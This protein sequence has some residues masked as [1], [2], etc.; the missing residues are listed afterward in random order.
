M[1]SIRPLPNLRCSE[2]DLAFNH[3]TDAGACKLFDALLAGAQDELST[4]RL[5][6]NPLT[7]E[8]IDASLAALKRA[9]PDM[10]T[11]LAPQLRGVS[12]PC[13]RVGIV[14]K[15]SPAARAGLQKGD[16]VLQWGMLQKNRPLAKRF[17][18]QPSVQDGIGEA[19]LAGCQYID[20]SSSISPLVRAFLGMPHDVIVRRPA[21]EAPPLA[22]PAAAA[23]LPSDGTVCLKLRLVPERWS[24]QGL[25]GCILK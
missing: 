22:G 12:E 10:E 19:F 3:L 23:P 20:V 6:G 5:G 13:C 15:N 18:F 9:R 17:G 2:L 25:L 8:G 11:D 7:S 4:L 14:Y 1:S 16:E 24:G 21:A